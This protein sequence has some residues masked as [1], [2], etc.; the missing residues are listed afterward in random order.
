MTGIKVP[1]TP[2][3][4]GIQLAELTDCLQK[5]LHLLE[6]KKFVA[7][8]EGQSSRLASLEAAVAM[9]GPKKAMFAT[10]QTS[11]AKATEHLGFFEDV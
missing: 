10:H 7:L 2:V 9:Q 1:Q 11:E 6:L 8:L 3:E 4:Q 5:K